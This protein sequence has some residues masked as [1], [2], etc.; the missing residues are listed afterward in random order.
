MLRHWDSE[1]YLC[2]ACIPFQKS[3]LGLTTEI[4]LHSVVFLGSAWENLVPK[5]HFWLGHRRP[6]AAAASD[7]WPREAQHLLGPG[8]AQIPNI[9]AA[10]AALKGETNHCKEQT[11]KPTSGS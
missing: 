5:G 2:Y 3:V 8:D 7:A 6:D 1:L 4:S 10:S 11:G 9:C